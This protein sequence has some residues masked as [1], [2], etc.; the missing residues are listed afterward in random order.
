MCCFGREKEP[1]C[2]SCGQAVGAEARQLLF[3]GSVTSFC[4]LECQRRFVAEFF[5]R[6]VEA[7]PSCAGKGKGDH[8]QQVG[9]HAQQAGGHGGA[10]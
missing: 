7:M 4:N 8:A 10:G 6:P 9:D 3:F 1:R 2:A 5:V